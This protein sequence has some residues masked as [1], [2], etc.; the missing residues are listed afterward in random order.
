[1][2]GW[3]LRYA[4]LTQIG[5]LQNFRSLELRRPSEVL[6]APFHPL[7]INTFVMENSFTGSLHE[8]ELP[9]GPS[10]SESNF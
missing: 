3:A 9:E 10:Y 6:R 7:Q 5:A 2:D 4:A 8:H 1:M